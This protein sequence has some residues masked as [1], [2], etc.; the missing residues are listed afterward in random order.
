MVGVV[1][2]VY[3]VEQFLHHQSIMTTFQFL[4][5]FIS[6]LA[7]ILSAITA[8]KTFFA[9][10][11]VEVWLKPRIILTAYSGKP[12]IVIG[13]ELSN[14]GTKTG[15]IDDI[16][17][18]IRYRQN[19]PRIIERYTFFPIL[20]RDDYNIFKIYQESDFE[21]FSSISVLAKSRLVKYIIFSPSNDS[22]SPFK[23]TA[24]IKLFFR[25]SGETRWKYSNNQA[26]LE[27]K[28]EDVNTW[29]NPQGQ[30]VMIETEENLNNKVKL[31]ESST[32]NTFD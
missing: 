2:I 5:V 17:L 4:T 15:S 21:Q 8:Y 10:F 16:V 18:A 13:C 3:P 31:L 12:V 11:K 32:Y 29:S 24:E 27:I 9:K 23:G 28:Q 19:S 6:T 7:L 20:A 22:F 1:V 25:S 26:T 14:G 30:S